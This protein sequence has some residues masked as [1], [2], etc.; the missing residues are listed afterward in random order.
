[1]EHAK[2]MAI[3]LFNYQF[4]NADGHVKTANLLKYFVK[5]VK[6]PSSTPINNLDIWKHMVNSWVIH[7]HTLEV[8]AFDKFKPKSEYY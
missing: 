6:K 1:M 4:L 3:K 5:M 8:S 2:R 7:F